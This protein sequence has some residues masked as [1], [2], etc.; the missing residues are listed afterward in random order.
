MFLLQIRFNIYSVLILIN[1]IFICGMTCPRL[2]LVQP[3]VLDSSGYCMLF[4]TMA[5]YHMI[6]RCVFF[7][8]RWIRLVEMN[9]YYITMATHYDI[10]LD[11]DIA[12]YA[13]SEITMGNAVARDIHCDVTMNNDILCVHIMSSQCIMTLLRTFSIMYSRLC[14]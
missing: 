9:Q 4:Y 13:H 7:E 11:N 1:L 5:Y 12:R 10:T 3:T 14:A 8:W 6:Y 2:W